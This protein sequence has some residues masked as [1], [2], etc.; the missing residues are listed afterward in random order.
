MDQELYDL[1][2]GLG[3]FTNRYEEIDAIVHEMKC[4][5]YGNEGLRDCV[6]EIGRYQQVSPRKEPSSKEIIMEYY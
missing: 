1:E 2:I 5:R 6:R 3:S 4:V